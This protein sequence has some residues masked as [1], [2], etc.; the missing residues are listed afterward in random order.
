MLLSQRKVL[1]KEMKKIY[2]CF[3]LIKKVV[4]KVIL[5]TVRLLTF[6]L[7]QWVKHLT[8]FCQWEVFGAIICP[9][10]HTFPAGLTV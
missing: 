10:I 6:L 2:L 4:I 5:I 7:L 8:Q 3:P 1:L 9:G